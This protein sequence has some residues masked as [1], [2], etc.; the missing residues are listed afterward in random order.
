MK[1]INSKILHDVLAKYQ[2]KF[3]NL[4][5]SEDLITKTYDQFKNRKRPKF[6]IEQK[7]FKDLKDYECKSIRKAFKLKTIKNLTPY[8]CWMLLIDG[9]LINDDA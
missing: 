9:P 5:N 3:P 1:K 7:H 2:V 6:I 4:A 8:D